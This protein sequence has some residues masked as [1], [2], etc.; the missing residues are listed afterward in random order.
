[1]HKKILNYKLG[2]KSN[3]RA[4]RKPLFFF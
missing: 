1:L 4:M 3:P 2:S